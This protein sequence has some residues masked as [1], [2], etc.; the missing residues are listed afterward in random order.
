MAQQANFKVADR[1]QICL[2]IPYKT[3]RDKI[4]IVNYYKNR[5]YYIEIWQ[6]YIYCSRG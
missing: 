4:K 3:I 2:V 5:G 1:V 6:D